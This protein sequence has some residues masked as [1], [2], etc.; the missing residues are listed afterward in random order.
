MVD[1]NQ[2]LQYYQPIDV[3]KLSGENAA[4]PDNIRNSIILYNKAIESLRISSEDIAVI[5]LK[6]AVSMNPSFYEAINLLGICYLLIEDFAK[7][8]L[9]FERVALAEAN[10][11]NAFRYLGIVAETV[12]V[13]E[14]SKLSGINLPASSDARDKSQSSN[15]NSRQSRRDYSGKSTGSNTRMNTLRYIAGFLIGV[16]ICAVFVLSG[17]IDKNTT[18]LTVLNTQNETINKKY[19]LLQTQYNNL[20]KELSLQKDLVKTANSKVDYYLLTNKLFE[21]YGLY[22]KKDYEGAADLLLLI[23]DTKYN[24]PAASFYTSLVSEV[25]PLAAKSAYDKGRSYLTSKNYT[26][27]INIFQK[28]ELYYKGF[29]EMDVVYYDIGRCYQALNDL[30][31]ADDAYQKVIDNFPDSQYAGY[32]AARIKEM[33]INP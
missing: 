9:M 18:D 27:A 7:A 24:D 32:S 25:L 30:T 12:G 13:E 8:E 23:K 3:D 29:S 22:S 6:K 31:N 19:E 20:D 33:G 5:E 2:E 15:K 21:I 28:V 1:I 17:G 10:G 26:D 16:F 11:I 14:Y 4:I